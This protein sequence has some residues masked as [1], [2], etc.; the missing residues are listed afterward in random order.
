[1]EDEKN[2]VTMDTWF[3]DDDN[4]NISNDLCKTSKNVNFLPEYVM[5]MP[6]NFIDI[7]FK[8][9][10]HSMTHY[11][12]AEHTGDEDDEKSVNSRASSS[13][14]SSKSSK[15][16]RSSKKKK[17]KQKSKEKKKSREKDSV[18]LPVLAVGSTPGTRPNSVSST[19][20]SSSS[21]GVPTLPSI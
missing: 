10:S 15:S 9:I 6:H 2:K 7:Y 14:K 21:T 3:N 1:M 13:S 5:D 12:Q 17:K 16:S 20:L 8:K 18:A 19:A 4:T 11:D